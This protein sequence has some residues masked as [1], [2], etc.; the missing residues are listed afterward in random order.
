MNFL[1]YLLHDLFCCKLLGYA[2][3]LIAS[4]MLAGRMI[5]VKLLTIFIVYTPKLL[6]SLLE[7]ALVLIYW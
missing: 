2:D 5:Y 1:L 6:Y 3:S 4:I 7:L